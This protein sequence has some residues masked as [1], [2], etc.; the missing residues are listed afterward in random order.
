M[1]VGW[2]VGNLVVTSSI[3]G[4]GFYTIESYSASID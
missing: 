2:E 3:L 4:I 1:G